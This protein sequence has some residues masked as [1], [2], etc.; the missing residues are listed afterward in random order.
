MVHMSIAIPS[1][2][3]AFNS[4][5]SILP[6]S[7]VR[8]RKKGSV[9]KDKEADPRH[10]GWDANS[11][12]VSWVTSSSDIVSSSHYEDKRKCTWHISQGGMCGDWVAGIVAVPVLR[13]WT[14]LNGSHEKTVSK[15]WDFL[16]DLQVRRIHHCC[17]FFP[18][19]RQKWAVQEMETI[20]KG[21]LRER[22]SHV[23]P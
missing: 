20:P 18:Q 7:V 22:T 1:S 15:S 13:I 3:S 9:A 17:L 2:P 12:F 4:F 19:K 23:K 21:W 14:W 5:Q 16:R 10:L 8:D 11:T 6:P